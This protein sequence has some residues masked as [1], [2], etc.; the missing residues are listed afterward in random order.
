MVIVERKIVTK[1]NSSALFFNQPV[2]G[3]HPPE[4]TAYR[5]AM[6][7]Y[8]QNGTYHGIYEYSDD[9]LTQTQVA[10]YNSIEVYNI[11]ENLLNIAFDAAYYSH[12]VANNLLHP[13]SG[14][15]TQTGI[16]QPFSC[17]TVY[18][19]NPEDISMFETLIDTIETSF[20]LE[21]FTNTGTV[22]T[23][24]HH[25]A[26]SEDFTE[27]HWKDFNYAPYLHAEG[28]TRSITYAL[29]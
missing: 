28:V 27:N 25:Y 6:D 16:N 12:A 18:T 10:T 11:S 15:Y 9:K 17:T 13:G 19:F 21:S 5:S 20:C 1:P 24:V 7:T 22:V 3:P 2:G 26:D 4:L 14:Q 29:L 8:V 23:A